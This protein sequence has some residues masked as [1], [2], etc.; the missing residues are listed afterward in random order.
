VIFECT[1]LERVICG[2]TV[3]GKIVSGD[4]IGDSS[5]PNG[6]QKLSPYIDEI[7]VETDDGTDITDWLTKDSLRSIEESFLDAVLE[8]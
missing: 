3:K 2:L 1:E 8:G 5:I 4:W 6:T 7:G